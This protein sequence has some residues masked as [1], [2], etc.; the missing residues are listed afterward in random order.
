M[1]RSFLIVLD[2]VAILVGLVWTGQG[3]GL[4]KGSF[5][6]GSGLWLVVGLVLLVVGGG[7][8]A[9]LALKGGTPRS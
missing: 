5:M 1:Y 4:I 3:I 6:T 8:L 2:I 9:L 7:H